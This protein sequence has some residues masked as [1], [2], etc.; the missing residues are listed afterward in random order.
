MKVQTQYQQVDGTGTFYIDP[1]ARIVRVQICN[2]SGFTCRVFLSSEDAV[3][4]GIALA[5]LGYWSDP[6]I[7]ETAGP[8]GA[9]LIPEEKI[10]YE[11]APG[12]QIAFLLDVLT[13]E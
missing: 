8:D 10:I 3:T 7:L 12:G 1:E 5:K 4:G 2:V 9:L 11:C 6:I 13:G